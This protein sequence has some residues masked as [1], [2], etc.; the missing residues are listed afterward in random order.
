MLFFMHIYNFCSCFQ[1][2]DSLHKLRQQTEV[3]ERLILLVT[4]DSIDMSSLKEGKVV[5]CQS[6]MYVIGFFTV[7][8]AAKWLTCVTVVTLRSRLS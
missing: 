5:C 6:F 1:E 7:V 3:F 4:S 2:I 8:M